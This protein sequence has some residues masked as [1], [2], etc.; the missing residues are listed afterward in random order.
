MVCKIL[1]H[2]LVCINIIIKGV[3]ITKDFYNKKGYILNT[4]NND[5]GFAIRYFR[6]QLKISQN[7]LCKGICSVAT[8]S[9]I[10]V[11]ERNADFLLLEALLERMGKTIDCFELVLSDFEYEYLKKREQINTLIKKKDFISANELLTSFKELTDF[12][13][14]VHK[15]YIKRTGALLNEL[16]GGTID[17]TILLLTEAI[18]YTVPNFNSHILINYCMSNNELR[19]SI[20]IIDCMIKMG[21]INESKDL[22]FQTLDFLEFHSYSFNNNLFAHVAIISCRLFIKENNYDK[23]LEICNKGLKKIETNITLDY[24]GDLLL[25]KAKVIERL[26]KINRLKN[27]DKSEILKL[28][29]QAYYVYL[30]TDEQI[31]VEEIEKYLKEEYYWENTD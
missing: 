7:K 13:L 31:K 26:L 10:E 11:G 19:I 20:D 23:A 21:K 25:V 2:I 5:I 28:Y 8:L 27:Y 24:K 29:K 3:F 6:E 16:Q 12:K 4:K 22:L 9:R 18:L 14:T 15:Q 1:T 17:K 30:F